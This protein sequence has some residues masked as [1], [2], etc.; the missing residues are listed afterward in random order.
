MGFACPSK[1]CPS[2]SKQHDGAS[3]RRWV[4]GTAE[5]PAWGLLAACQV[6]HG[7]STTTAHNKAAEIPTV[8][9]KDVARAHARWPRPWLMCSCCHGSPCTPSHLMRVPMPCDCPCTL[10]M[11]VAHAHTHHPD[12][13]RRPCPPPPPRSP[14]PPACHA[15]RAMH[16]CLNE[17]RMCWTR[18]AAQGGG[19]STPTHLNLLGLDLLGSHGYI[20]SERDGRSASA[21][22]A[23]ISH[24][25]V[26]R[27]IFPG[28]EC[29][30]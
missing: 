5:K 30:L 26:R 8:M 3:V 18:R 23:P 14:Q 12:R 2:M 17:R 21:L 20:G 7:T 22:A 1:G 9:G 25:D 4:H 28:D 15:M 10:T 24:F 13:A 16:A 29:T 19:T 27:N 11:Q 6:A